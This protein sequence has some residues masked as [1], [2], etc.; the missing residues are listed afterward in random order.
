[1]SWSKTCGWFRTRIIF[2]VPRR[3]SR[4]AYISMHINVLGVFH[5]RSLWF[6]YVHTTRLCK[7]SYQ[8]LCMLSTRS[9]V[10]EELCGTSTGIVQ[11]PGTLRTTYCFHLLLC[12]SFYTTG[13][14]PVY[15]CTYP[16][17]IVYD[18]KYNIY[19]STMFAHEIWWQHYQHF[20]WTH[21]I[22]T[23]RFILYMTN[24]YNGS[25]RS[26]SD[27]FMGVVRLMIIF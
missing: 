7:Y 11:V 3:I 26:I 25:E 22:H 19:Q 21:D 8:H 27:V 15:N 4:D 18:H 13:T 10:L 12:D 2:R 14:F 23:Y 9:R 6:I 5:S 17:R 1:M 24:T 16:V 20:S